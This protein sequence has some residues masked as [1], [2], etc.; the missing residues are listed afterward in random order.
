MFD[1]FIHHLVREELDLSRIKSVI[2]RYQMIGIR[3]RS[4]AELFRNS[5]FSKMLV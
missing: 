1:F 5:F 2:Q 3:Q 4:Q